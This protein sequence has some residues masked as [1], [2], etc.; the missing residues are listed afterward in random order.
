MGIAILPLPG[1]VLCTGEMVFWAMQSEIQSDVD[2]GVIAADRAA[3]AADRCW[4]TSCWSRLRSL[5]AAAAM[6]ALVDISE[7]EEEEESLW[8]GR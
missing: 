1:L 5:L 8:R 7:G 3:A 4:S 2:A 6:A